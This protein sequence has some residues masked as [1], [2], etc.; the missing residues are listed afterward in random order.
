M[1]WKAVKSSP[2]YGKI[3]L[4]FAFFGGI[5]Y[6]LRWGLSCFIASDWSYLILS[7]LLILLVSIVIPAIEDTLRANDSAFEEEEIVNNKIKDNLLEDSLTVIEECVNCL[8]FPDRYYRYF[9]KGD[10][11]RIY[12][13]SVPNFIYE[14]LD[15]PE[16][17]RLVDE[18]Y[19]L[20]NVT[21]SKLLNITSD[22]KYR[23][24][25]EE[26][27]KAFPSMIK[28]IEELLTAHYEIEP[29]GSNIKTYCAKT[30]DVDKNYIFHINKLTYLLRNRDFGG[31]VYDRKAYNRSPR[32]SI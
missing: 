6:T 28:K 12:E 21:S 25:K 22:S 13:Y 8:Q 27:R 23:P 5:S 11:D 9:H 7:F 31:M 16:E 10:V 19:H 24:S 32:I 29:L 17:N 1:I 26:V 18:I 4:L 14:V 30:F 2:K 3:S 20:N 15:I